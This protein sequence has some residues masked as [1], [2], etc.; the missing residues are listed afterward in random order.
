[1]M[2]RRWARYGAAALLAC[3]LGAGAVVAVANPPKGGFPPDPPSQATRKQWLF[4]VSYKGGVASATRARAAMRD[5]PAGSARVFGRFAVELWV[6]KELL[7]RVRFNVPLTGDDR[8]PAGAENDPDRRTDRSPFKRPSFDQVTTRT[9]VQIADSPRAAWA[10][11]IDRA[12]GATRR[13]WWPPEPNGT[14]LPMVP[15]AGVDGGADA[16]DGGPRPAGTVT[17]DGGTTADADVAPRDAGAVVRDAS[18]PRS[19]STPRS[20]ASDAGNP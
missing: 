11:L 13:Y 18:P 7:D 19:P 1:M 8:D 4:D 3:A 16:G 5:K 10:Q 15:A 14:L 17:K 2:A 6:G 9:V 12:T 20:P